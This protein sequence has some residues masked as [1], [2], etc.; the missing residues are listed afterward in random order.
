MQSSWSTR[1]SL[2]LIAGLFLVVAPSWERVQPAFAADPA[3]S[4]EPPAATAPDE[5]SQHPGVEPNCRAEVKK[6]CGGVRP[7]G[8][9][10]KQCIQDNESKL[11]PA[12]QKKV[13]SRLEQEGLTKR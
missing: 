3:Q 1:V 12:C 6:L 13:G 9:R 5:Q 2:S 7:G 10:I 11:S 4:P 8:G